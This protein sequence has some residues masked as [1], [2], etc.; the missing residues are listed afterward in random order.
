MK[1]VNSK[2]PPLSQRE[3]EYILCVQCYCDGNFP[4]LLTHK[5]FKKVS[6]NDRIDPNRKKKNKRRKKDRRRREEEAEAGA[7]EEEAKE[8]VEEDKS[9]HDEEEEKRKKEDLSNAMARMIEQSGQRKWSLM[10]TSYLLEVLEKHGENWAEVHKEMRK[11]GYCKDIPT[12]EIIK[13]F[14]TLP[15]RGVTKLKEECDN[16]SFIEANSAQNR[17]SLSQK[18]A[19][20]KL[21]EAMAFAERAGP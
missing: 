11:R 5:D 19:E 21:D 12:E 18:L 14:L 7:N 16:E 20:H 3:Y 13:Y 4:L 8:A 9:H 1:N 17:N 2:N 15:T 10:E 6:A